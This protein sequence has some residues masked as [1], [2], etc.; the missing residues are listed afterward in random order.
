MKKTR[1]ILPCNFILPFARAINEKTRRTVT[2]PTAYL[3][4]RIT[5]VGVSNIIS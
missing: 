3:S 5:K 4:E 2:A 1:F